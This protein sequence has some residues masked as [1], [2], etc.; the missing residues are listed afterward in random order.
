MVTRIE[1]TPSADQ[2]RERRVLPLQFGDR[3][4]RVE[5]HR[6]YQATP[7]LKKAELIEGVVYMPLPV[8]YQKH[9]R[10]HGFIMTCLGVYAATTPHLDF[11]DN[12]SVVLD[13]ENEIQPDALLRKVKGT[14]FIN[15]KGFLEGA[16]ELIIEIAASTASYDLYDKF[17]V[18]RRAQVQEYVVWRVLDRAIDWFYLD[19][20]EYK[21]LKPHENG[22][23]ESSVFPGFHLAVEALLNDDLATVLQ[24]LQ[25]GLESQE[26]EEFVQTQSQPSPATGE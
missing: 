18:Y 26:H 22:V 13:A 14:S 9:G 8:S 11:G 24:T 6:R 25:T 1:T 23:I 2:K 3:L 15:L 19:E 16:P 5:F 4:T 12:A 7:D 20:G 17:R 21:Q 10:P